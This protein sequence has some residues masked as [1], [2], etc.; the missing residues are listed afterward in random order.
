MVLL[1]ELG[2]KGSVGIVRGVLPPVL[3]TATGTGTGGTPDGGSCA[4]G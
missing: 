1:G 3:A 2:L 4:R